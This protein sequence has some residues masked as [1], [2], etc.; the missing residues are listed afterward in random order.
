MRNFP[1]VLICCVAGSLI[2]VNW[3]LAHQAPP[4]GQPAPITS[5]NTDNLE[6]MLRSGQTF[7]LQIELENCPACNMLKEE[8]AES[9]C[10]NSLPDKYVLYVESANKEAARTKIK[11]L[12]PS[13]EYY[14]SLYRINTG[15]LKEFK[16]DTLENFDE[17]LRLWAS[18]FEL[19]RTS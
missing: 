13:F 15:D 17:R 18:S 9:P 3:I 11:Q 19:L 5:I 1:V 8:E 7:F 4:P 16:L 2:A 6:E 14:P 12:I 10:W